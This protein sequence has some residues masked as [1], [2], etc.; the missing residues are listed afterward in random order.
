[1][2]T[3]VNGIRDPPVATI[4]SERELVAIVIWHQAGCTVVLVT[5]VESIAHT[6][7]PGTHV[8][9]RGSDRGCYG[10]DRFSYGGDRVGTQVLSRSNGNGASSGFGDRSYLRPRERSRSRDM[11]HG[12]GGERDNERSRL[13]ER[14]HDSR[15]RESRTFTGER[16][17]ERRRECTIKGYNDRADSSHG[18]GGCGG[19]GGN[20][21][22]HSGGV[23][24]DSG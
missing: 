8:S 1:M 5:W 24:S 13:R 9:D 21:N 7:V 14:D 6:I 23:Y 16:N 10:R 3:L 2:G 17:R 12:T 18:R 4:M 15:G 11:V 19:S 20:T 22:Y